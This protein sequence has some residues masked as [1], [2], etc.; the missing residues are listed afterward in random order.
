MYV[1]DGTDE[2]T[3]GREDWG[4][5]G[6]PVYEVEAMYLPP[7]DGSDLTPMLVYES[8]LRLAG[9]ALRLL[10]DLLSPLMRYRVEW[11]AP[12]FSGGYNLQG[13]FF[14]Y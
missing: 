4:I 5:P 11:P 6:H 14:G 13:S 12:S 8:G 10:N 9:S 1:A 2:V 7:L 3:N